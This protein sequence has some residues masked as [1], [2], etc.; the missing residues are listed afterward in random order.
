[1]RRAVTVLALVAGG[2]V[3]LA[4]ASHLVPFELR[5]LSAESELIVV[6]EV[7]SVSPVE[8]DSRTPTPFDQVELNVGAVIKGELVQRSLSIVLE[9]RGVRGF[10]PSLTAGQTGVFF[11]RKTGDD[12]VRPVTFEA[13]ALF[14]NR[15]FVVTEGG[16]GRL[17]DEPDEK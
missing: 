9:P 17:S 4:S 8:I 12:R 5:D 15:N 11:L 1:M 14:G 16:S 13:V 3:G 2:L 10:D 7:M 6:A